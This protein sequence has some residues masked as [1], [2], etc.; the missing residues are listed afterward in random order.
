[1]NWE[2]YGNIVVSGGSSM[3]PGFA[4]RVRKEISQLAPASVEV[5]VVAPPD[6]AHAV[7]NGG[8]LVASGSWIQNQ[9]IK[10]AEYD[11]YGPSIIHRKLTTSSS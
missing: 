5:N 1:M 7:W 2:L 6:S 8:S 10:K 9:W 3:F 4:H 11:D